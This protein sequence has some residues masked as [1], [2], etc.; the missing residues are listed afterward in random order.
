MLSKLSNPSI[1]FSNDSVSQYFSADGESIVFLPQLNAWE[2]PSETFTTQPWKCATRNCALVLALKALGIYRPRVL[3]IDS[4][5]NLSMFHL[6]AGFFHEGIDICAVS[7]GVSWDAICG[8]DITVTPFSSTLDAYLT[9]NCGGYDAEERPA[10]DGQFI[11][12]CGNA[13][14]LLGD[15]C[16]INTP[17]GDYVSAFE[18]L[19]KKG[20]I[21]GITWQN[22]RHQCTAEKLAR[23]MAKGTLSQRTIDIIYGYTDKEGVV[24]KGYGPFKPCST[25]QANDEVPHFEWMVGLMRFVA[26]I[27][28]FGLDLIYSAY[29]GACMR[30]VLFRVYPISEKKPFTPTLTGPACV[31]DFYSLFSEDDLKAHNGVLFSDYLVPV[32]K[33]AAREL[34]KADY[35]LIADLWRETA[36]LAG[37]QM[38]PDAQN[39]KKLKGK[40][41]KKGKK[42]TNGARG[43]EEK[44]EEEDVEEEI[45]EKRRTRS[46]TRR[47]AVVAVE[48]A[49]KAEKKAEEPEKKIYLC[50]N[51]K[52]T[53][54][55][56]RSCKM[57]SPSAPV[58]AAPVAAAP[59]AL[60]TLDVDYLIN[61][62]AV[63]H[64]G[65]HI[66]PAYRHSI[67][68]ACEPSISRAPAAP[69]DREGFSF[70]GLCYK[71]KSEK[72][73]KSEK[74]EPE[75]LKRERDEEVEENDKMT[76]EE[77]E[78]NEE[79]EEKKNG[80][81][82]TYKKRL[83]EHERLS[84]ENNVFEKIFFWKK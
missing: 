12:A 83:P 13:P 65:G 8:D 5:A 74:K 57:A 40:K 20:G 62:R 34:N 59:S 64:K 46:T 61:G 41:G 28:G 27:E 80:E 9:H 56:S 10:F 81:R 82:R 73:E 26:K 18:S 31:K 44:E 77:V 79:V 55:N 4:A 42:T 16:G 36:S 51:C 69:A 19:T 35:T 49:E 3:V 7:H 68:M 47:S 21:F 67:S 58:P 6:A 48:K 17:S 2:N 78:E 43:A 22:S 75:I 30:T 24:H 52:Q 15:I 14:N 84:R 38:E 37:V 70:C 63:I 72:S 66:C 54:H 1:F 32:F 53:G 29:V 23:K 39:Q 11:D 71:S 45:V 25:D 50:G 76:S 33:E 60:R